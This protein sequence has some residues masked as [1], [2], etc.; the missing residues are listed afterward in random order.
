VNTLNSLIPIIGA[1]LFLIAGVGMIGDELRARRNRSPGE[2]P[3]ER[4]SP[5]MLLFI[6]IVTFTTLAPAVIAIV[7]Y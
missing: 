7:S 3:I 6:V 2:P 4:L 5:A 1:V